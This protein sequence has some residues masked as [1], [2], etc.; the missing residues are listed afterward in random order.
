MKKTEGGYRSIL[1]LCLTPHL[2]LEHRA[3]SHVP[4]KAATSCYGCYLP[5]WLLLPVM[6]ATSTY[7]NYFLSWQLLPGIELYSRDPSLVLVSGGKRN[8]ISSRE[9]KMHR[10]LTPQIPTPTSARL[11][12]SLHLA[13]CELP[14]A[15]QLR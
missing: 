3:S 9:V 1:L 14:G 7:G 13:R 10:I 8:S 6:A 2:L 12:T 5:L 4:I 11:Y 15:R